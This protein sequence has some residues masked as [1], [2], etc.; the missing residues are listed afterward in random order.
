MKE[1]AERETSADNDRRVLQSWHE[2]VVYEGECRIV[3]CVE[4]G[5]TA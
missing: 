2:W 5:T 1:S 4:D 3:L